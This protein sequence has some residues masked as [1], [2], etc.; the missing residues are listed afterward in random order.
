ML[1]LM[2]LQRG[3]QAIQLVS[4]RMLSAI[5]TSTACITICRV[6]GTVQAVVGERLFLSSDGTVQNAIANDRLARAVLADAKAVLRDRRS[7]I[8]RY[9]LA[10]GVVEVL[11]ELI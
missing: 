8:M 7:F 3:S 6:E 10:T 5:A 2:R 4:A 9:S 11:A 1:L